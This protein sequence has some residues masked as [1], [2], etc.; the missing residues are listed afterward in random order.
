MRQAAVPYRKLQNIRVV[1]LDVDGIL[2]DGRIVLES[3]SGVGGGMSE[4][5]A[6]HA[7]DGQGLIFARQ[8]GFHVGLVTSRESRIVS[9]RA[10]ELGI[11]TVFQNVKEKLPVVKKFLKERRYRHE[12][13]LYMGDDFLDLPVLRFAGFSATVPESPRIIRENVDYVT[14]R[15][16]GFGAVREVL[17]ML[18]KIQGRWPELVGRF[19]N[20]SK[21]SK[22]KK[23][24]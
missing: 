8:L 12:H 10:E 15:P 9:R 21:K 5:K 23:S 14:D 18:F 6:F 2:T 11:P 17:E 19:L 7:L 1:M 4:S 22:Y 20:G 13:L 16:G 3:E 24:K